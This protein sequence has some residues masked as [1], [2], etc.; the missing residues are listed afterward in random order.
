VFLVAFNKTGQTM[1]AQFLIA[2]FIT[3]HMSMI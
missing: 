1:F 2:V 3:S